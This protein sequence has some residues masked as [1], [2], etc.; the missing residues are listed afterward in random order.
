MKPIDI[1]DA[2]EAYRAQFPTEASTVDDFAR[3][4]DT[5]SDPTSRSSFPGHFTCSAVALNDIGSILMVHHRALQRWLCPG[6]HI[7]AEDR[8]PRAAALRELYE[9]TGIT[10]THLLPFDSWLDRIPVQIDRH[11]IPANEAKGEPAH[12]HYDLRFAFRC[13]DTA[14]TPQEAEVTDV[15]WRDASFLSE[16]LRRRLMELGLAR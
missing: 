1:R 10:E 4:L 16:T 7:E 2:L 5:A 8:S 9:E 3:L 12:E 14:F 6:G 15:Q 11:G 13:A